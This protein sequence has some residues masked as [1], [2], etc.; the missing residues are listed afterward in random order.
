MA[1]SLIWTGRSNT[2]TIGLVSSP[3]QSFID[4]VG[5][6]GRARIFQTIGLLEAFGLELTFPYC[7]HLDGKLWEL[8]VKSGS[9]QYRVIYFAHVGQRFILLHAFEKRQKKTP[10]RELQ[11]AKA[12]LA[13]IIQR[14]V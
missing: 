2:T 8:R 12:R 6:A 10:P 14:G 5:A 7:S 11:V 3:V 13:D 1:V 4:S 9:S